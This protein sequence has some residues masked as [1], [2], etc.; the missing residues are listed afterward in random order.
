MWKSHADVLYVRDHGAVP[1]RQTQTDK[2]DNPFP[3]EDTARPKSF[4][5]LTLLQQGCVHCL[6]ELMGSLAMCVCDCFYFQTWKES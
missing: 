4:L 5:A 1:G 6:Q 2:Q 3:C